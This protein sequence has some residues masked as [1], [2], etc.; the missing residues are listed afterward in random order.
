MNTALTF[1]LVVTL[2]PRFVAHLDGCEQPSF[3]DYQNG[4]PQRIEGSPHICEILARRKSGIEIRS[5]AEVNEV[6]Y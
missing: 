1:P 3:E 6:Y 5:A 2:A 4:E